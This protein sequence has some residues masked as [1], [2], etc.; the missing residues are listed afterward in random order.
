MRIILVDGIGRG[1]NPYKK[2]IKFPPVGRV[3]GS[4]L[5]KVIYATRFREDFLPQL[6][7]AIYFT[8]SY[9]QQVDGFILPK[10]DNS[11]GTSY[12]FIF[13]GHEPSILK[14]LVQ[15]CLMRSLGLPGIASDNSGSLL[16]LWNNKY[17]AQYIPPFNP[18][19]I[20]PM[21][22]P[23]LSPEYK[24][25]ENKAGN[26][27]PTDFSNFDIFITKLLYSPAIQNGTSYDKINKFLSL[28]K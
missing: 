19:T 17:Q 18:D 13:E 22:K 12:C 28:K 3:G 10:A 2:Y 20:Y 6:K 1:A 16:G 14:T 26:S 4:P 27:V 21:D 8:P 9:Y 11:I 15:E 24:S 5:H 23:E 7:T 25:Q